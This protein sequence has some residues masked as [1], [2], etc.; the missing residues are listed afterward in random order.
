M[1]VDK[2]T[3]RA[4]IPLPGG[5]GRMTGPTLNLGE[6]RVDDGDH[7]NRKGR[8]GSA[9]SRPRCCSTRTCGAV[10][11]DHATVTVAADVS[12]AETPDDVLGRL[13]YTLD[14]HP[15]GTI[16][17]AYDLA[18][19]AADA[20]AWEFGL[21]FDLPAAYDHLGWYRDAAVD[22]VPARHIGAVAGRVDAKDVSFRSDQAGH[23]LGDDDRR[24][25]RRVRRA[26]DDHAAARPRGVTPAGTVL[27]ASAAEYAPRS[28][29]SSYL[30]NYRIVL[31]RGKS[32]A[33]AFT[34]RPVA[35]PAGR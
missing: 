27:V 26:A 29:S 31:T 13:T 7:R 4:S 18:W 32:K 11:G 1:T 30:D 2:A 14:V 12:L 8:R 9:A 25:R 5:G 35:A 23:G 24:R 28:F 15:D 21:T 34:L 33:G 6:R 17:V 19:T 3:G 10:A 16:D 22:G 20:N